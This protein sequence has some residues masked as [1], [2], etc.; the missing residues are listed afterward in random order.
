ME[1]IMTR[2]IKDFSADVSI[3]NN[4]LNGDTKTW[5]LIEAQVKRGISTWK[6]SPV[7]DWESVILE[8]IWKAA[9]YYKPK[10]SFKG[11]VI[12]VARCMLSNSYNRETSKNQHNKVSIDTCWDMPETTSSCLE[13]LIARQEAT[14]IMNGNDEAS[15]MAKLMFMGLSRRQIAALIGA[16]KYRIYDISQRLKNKYHQ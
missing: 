13:V 16:D 15:L 5:K 4:I 12:N 10:S 6:M 11:F 9:K 3:A 14:R 7:V 1:T 8:A 2:K